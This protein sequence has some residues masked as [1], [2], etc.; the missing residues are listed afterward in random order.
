M[1]IVSGFN[2][3]PREVEEV[4]HSHP[5]IAE[6]AVI[7]RPDPVR[8]EALAAFIVLRAALTAESLRAWLAEQL[9]RYKLPTDLLFVDA[10]P[11]TGVGKIDKAA[12]ATRLKG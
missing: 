1:V 5:A 7:G 8:G 4:L 6:A 10:L 12:L 11:R 9:T 3:Y 2:V